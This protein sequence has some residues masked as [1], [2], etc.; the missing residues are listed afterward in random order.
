MALYYFDIHDG[1]FR[2]DEEGTECADFDAVRRE[3]K[4][5]LPEIAKDILPE[6]GDHHTLTVRVRNERHETVYTATLM[7]NGFSSPPEFDQT[8]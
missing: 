8:P 5:V 6:D 4:R 7:F 1:T 3:A 2:L